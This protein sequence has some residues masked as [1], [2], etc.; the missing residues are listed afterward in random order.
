MKEAT[1]AVAVEKPKSKSKVGTQVEGAEPTAMKARGPRTTEDSKFRILDGV[2]AGK[3]RG[4][5]Q[6]V[7]KAI[8]SLG[9]G[10]HTIAQIAAKSEGLVSKT[11]VEASVKYHLNGLVQDGHVEATHPEPVVKEKKEKAAKAEETKEELVGA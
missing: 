10:H 4:Q 3:F 9:E 6:I 11:P 7:V 1:E 2:D 5:R 8:Q